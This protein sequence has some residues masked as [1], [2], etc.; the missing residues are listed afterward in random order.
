MAFFHIW[1]AAKNGT[2]EEKTAMAPGSPSEKSLGN[3]GHPTLASLASWWSDPA[4]FTRLCKRMQAANLDSRLRRGATPS[5][6]LGD[7]R[8]DGRPGRLGTMGGTLERTS[9]PFADTRD[10]TLPVGHT[11]ER[12]IGVGV[13]F[14]LHARE[15]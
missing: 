5:P 10:H 4:F 9:H 13:I 8:R 12:V 15:R 7:R 6:R 3:W 1:P 14:Q 2:E 11:K